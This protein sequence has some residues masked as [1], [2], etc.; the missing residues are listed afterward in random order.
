METVFF[1]VLTYL[2]LG[3]AFFI[4]GRKL[5]EKLFSS[6]KSSCADGCAGCTS[7]CELKSLVDSQKINRH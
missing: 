5:F 3:F 7:K 2:I 1:T 6:K 4:A